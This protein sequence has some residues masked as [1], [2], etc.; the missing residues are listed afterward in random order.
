M[1]EPLPIAPRA[2]SGRPPRVAVVHDW[3]VR[4]DGSV[5]TLAEI[6]RCFPQAELYALVDFL[7]AADR[8]P[9]GG[10]VARTS[11]LQRMPFIQRLY[12]YYLPLMPFAVEQLDLRGYDLVVSSSSN[13]AKGVVVGPDQVHV[14]Y[15]YSPMRFVWELQGHYLER[16]GW[17][18]GPK[19]WLAAAAFHRLRQWDRGSTHGVDLLLTTSAYV[20]RRIQKAYRRPATVVHPPVDTDRFVPGGRRRGYYLTAAYMNPF[21][22]V[23]LI[24][25]AFARLPDRELVVVGD[26]PERDR[27]R[28]M[29]P[30]NA[31]F[32]GAV[33]D[34]ALV[35]L[36]QEA[37]AF[38]YAAPED[39]GIVLAEAQACGTPVIALGVGGACEIVRGLD[40]ATP[41]GVL[42]DD[43]TPAALADAV[44][45]FEGAEGAI[46]PE[47]CRE[48]ALRFHASVF[49]R[50]LVECV[51]GAAP[52]L[53][54]PDAPDVLAPGPADALAPGSM[55]P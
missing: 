1:S 40:D 55:D 52:H 27:L 47:A 7:P 28:R 37:R 8:A 5:R 50:R 2:A 6:L 46:R 48:N 49:R 20:A 31:T 45:R 9:L 51:S 22:N 36:M 19:R 23:E 16:F 43:P 14:S 38:V 18:R 4:M 25:R 30:P 12:W 44:A 53:R 26:G 34:A 10:R 33:D 24:L 21:K 42:Y 41:T 29:A 17:N 11:F 39:F 15:V 32:L 13:V 54:L 35:G 3:L